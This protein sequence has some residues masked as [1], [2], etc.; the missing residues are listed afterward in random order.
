MELL[1]DKTVKIFDLCSWI[2]VFSAS[3][4]LVVGLWCSVH[5]LYL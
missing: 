3:L 5:H 2:V 1:Y 4:V